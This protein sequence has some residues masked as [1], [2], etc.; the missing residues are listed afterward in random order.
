[1]EF[2]STWGHRRDYEG[3]AKGLE[4]FDVRLPEILGSMTDSDMLVI[5][6]DHGCDPTFKGTD[7]TREKVPFLMYSKSL[8]SNGNLGEVEGFD[9]I[10]SFIKD[11]I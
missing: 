6:A 5:T 11:W 3:Y 7:H 9:T 10:A 8:P 1:M 4:E 2:D